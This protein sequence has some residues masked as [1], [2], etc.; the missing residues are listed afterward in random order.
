M[1]GKLQVLI[2]DDEEN[3]REGLKWLIDWETIG[4][5][6]MG[7]ARNGEEAYYIC[8]EQEVDVVLT[9]IRMPV[10]DGLALAG[11]LYKERNGIIV[12]IMSA[13]KDFAYAQEAIQ[14]HV[15]SYILKPVNSEKLCRELELILTRSVFSEKK[16][17]RQ[18]DLL[19]KI[20]FSQ[21]TKEEGAELEIGMQSACF[22]CVQVRWEGKEREE[23]ERNRIFGE[24]SDYMEENGLGYACV[25]VSGHLV[26]LFMIPWEKKK[27][28]VRFICMAE[29]IL[30]HES[31]EKPL[32]AVGQCVQ[33][34]E[35]VHRSYCQ[36]NNMFFLDLFG[37]DDRCIFCDKL[38][39]DKRGMTIAVEELCSF[40]NSGQRHEI[41]LFMEGLWERAVKAH[42]SKEEMYGIAQRIFGEIARERPGFCYGESWEKL[43]EQR[44]ISELILYVKEI[45]LQ[46]T[47]VKSELSG[48]CLLAQ[49]VEVFVERHIG[50]M[51]LN[52]KYIAQALGYNPAYMGRVF[53][54]ARGISVKEHVNKKRIEQA[55]RKLVADNGPIEEIMYEV[56]Y[57][58]I[59]TF[60]EAFRRIKNITPKEYREKNRT[61]IGDEWKSRK[62]KEIQ[63]D[64]IRS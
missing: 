1:D 57:R 52:T 47:S 46:N 55:C 33:K 2:V 23:T 16:K 44:T 28:L 39:S 50:D 54:N 35:E 30:E 41:E 12:I 24:I 53:L 45:C 36:T 34:I 5:H 15:Q 9:D 13:Y 18:S 27:D 22:Q 48:S 43:L 10:M 6:V 8:R 37:N 64:S 51:R 60:Y 40:I 11:R 32:I 61:G 63:N 56:G 42:I 58:D 62:D 29:E 31:G 7:T 19:K 21:I 59:S 25:D 4:Y 38:I 14:Y 3:I 49:K 17:R 20:I 26:L